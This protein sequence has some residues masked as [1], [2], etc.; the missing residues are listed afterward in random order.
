MK[1]KP[2]HSRNRL[3][4]LVPKVE[5]LS[6]TVVPIT[7]TPSPGLFAN[8]QDFNYFKIYADTTAPNLSEYYDT[9]IWSTI[10]LQASEQ[11]HF[12]KH[13]IIALGAL[14]K[15]HEATASNK[16]VSGSP[17]YQVAF[18]HYGNSI[19][20]I[21]KACAEQRKSRR[22]ILIACLLAVCFEYYHGNIN[23]ATAHIKNGIRLR[24]YCTPLKVL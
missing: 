9:P 1:Q 17:H 18:Q 22:T 4:P 3:L 21:R 14:N 8:D 11:E 15:S 5:Y 24:E 16:G 19:Q 7:A 6:K 2:T 20:G 23:L 10:V 13:A 12:I